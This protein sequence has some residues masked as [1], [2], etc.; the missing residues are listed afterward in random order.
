MFHND[1][2]S[3]K[4]RAD[5]TDSIAGIIW[6]KQTSLKIDI[7]TTLPSNFWELLSWMDVYPRKE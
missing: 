1:G 5:R 3:I 2:S 6:T 7:I 4:H